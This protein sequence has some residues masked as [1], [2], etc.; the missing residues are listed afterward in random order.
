M[1]LQINL[2]L[3]A[4]LWNQAKISLKNSVLSSE[5]KVAEDSDE[6][7]PVLYFLWL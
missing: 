3:V 7:T 5:W 4:E 1:L 6:S 2:L